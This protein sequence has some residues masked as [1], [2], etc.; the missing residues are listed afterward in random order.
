MPSIA[1]SEKAWV[2]TGE[3]QSCNR[4][5][6]VVTMTIYAYGRWWL[7]SWVVDQGPLIFVFLPFMP[8]LFIAAMWGSL[9]FIAQMC[10]PPFSSSTILQCWPLDP[11]PMQ[12][13]TDTVKTHASQLEWQISEYV[14][15]FS[16]DQ[17][18][19]CHHVRHWISEEMSE[20]VPIMAKA[21]QILWQLSIVS[22]V[23]IIT[24]LS[25]QGCVCLST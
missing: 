4:A 12:C 19:T 7:M 13:H 2:S 5:V 20:Y 9:G 11:D 8:F 3:W 15:A 1:G 25:I 14:S 21:M 23:P 16:S 18:Y 24:H 10:F 17:T 6:P 22:L